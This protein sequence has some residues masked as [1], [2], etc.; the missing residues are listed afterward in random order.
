MEKC[1]HHGG[2]SRLSK[3]LQH[4]LAGGMGASAEGGGAHRGCVGKSGGRGDVVAVGVRS[5]NG[6]SVAW[7]E[8]ERVWLSNLACVRLAWAS[9]RPLPPAGGRGGGTRGERGD[10][11]TRED[12]MAGVVA[13]RGLHACG[14]CLSSC[15]DARACSVPAWVCAVHGPTISL[16]CSLSSKH[17]SMRPCCVHGCTRRAG[18]EHSTNAA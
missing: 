3:T 6:G 12:G 15:V 7:S 8:E 5:R 4:L 16:A 11:G 10:S 9:C 1:P 2:L 13:V 18:R 17:S 14:M